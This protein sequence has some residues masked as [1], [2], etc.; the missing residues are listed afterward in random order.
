MPR[1][2]HQRCQL[3]SLSITH[4]VKHCELFNQ[5]GAVKTPA[6]RGAVET[7]TPPPVAVHTGGTPKVA[8]TV[9]LSPS[10]P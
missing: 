3:D 4:F 7:P 9:G 5:R 1:P 2:R 8:T 10:H 6:Q